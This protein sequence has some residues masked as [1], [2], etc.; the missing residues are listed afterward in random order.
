MT[1][2]HLYRRARAV[3]GTDEQIRVAIEECG[4]LVVALSHM[5]RGRGDEEAVEE[6]ADAIIVAEQVRL[7]L[8]ADRVDA[9]VAVKLARLEERVAA[10]EGSRA[11]VVPLVQP[12]AENESEGEYGARIMFDVTADDDADR[13]FVRGYESGLL[14][15]RL[16]NK[17]ETWAGTYHASNRVMLE[18]IA[19]A[20][21]YT[22]TISRSTDPTWVYADFTKRAALRVVDS[23]PETPKKPSKVV[24]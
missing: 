10:A 11:E 8:G 6:C 13:A 22:V 3:F 12:L 19:V 5:Q 1:R 17:P 20:E 16:A 2:E 9:M 23:F 21:G 7:I 24:R 18:R 15:G 14:V 4:E